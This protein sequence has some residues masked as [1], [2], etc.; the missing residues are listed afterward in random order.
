[1]EVGAAILTFSGAM[2][3][4]FAPQLVRLFTPDPQ[5]I[6]LATRCLHQV[7]FIQ[8]IQVIAWI[9]AGALRGAGDTKWPFY[10]TAVCNWCIRTLGAYLCIRVFHLGLPEAVLC[11]CADSCVRALWTWLRFRTGK[12][13]DALPTQEKKGQTA[14]AAG[15]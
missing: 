5:A 2:I 8:P 12:W 4:I 15:N 11:A 6:A 3:Y 10:I 1:M 13:Q 7:A 14:A 9:L